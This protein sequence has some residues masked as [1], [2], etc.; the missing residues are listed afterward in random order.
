VLQDLA[1]LRWSVL[2]EVCKMILLHVDATL[3]SSL[4]SVCNFVSLL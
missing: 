4:A 1:Q 2:P 3:R